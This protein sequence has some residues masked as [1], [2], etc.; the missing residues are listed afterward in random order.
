ML[1]PRSCCIHPAY[2]H[3]TYTCMHFF[4][5]KIVICRAHRVFMIS[6][7]IRD[8]YFVFVYINMWYMGFVCSPKQFSKTKHIHTLHCLVNILAWFLLLS[9]AHTLIHVYMN[10]TFIFW[11]MVF[12]TYI[13]CVYTDNGQGQFSCTKKH[14]NWCCIAVIIYD[15]WSHANAR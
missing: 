11:I 3:F 7:H 10:N 1:M 12:S 9:C 6:F 14:I 4:L 15:C 13:S 2:A 5:L 8:M